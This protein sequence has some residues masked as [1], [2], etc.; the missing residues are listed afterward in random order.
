MPPLVG[1]ITTWIV[2]VF[3]VCNALL[4]SAAMLR[5]SIRAVDPEPNSAF[6]QFLDRQFNDERMEKHWPNMIATDGK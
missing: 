3:M 4:T 2:L 6:E 5:Y 1:K